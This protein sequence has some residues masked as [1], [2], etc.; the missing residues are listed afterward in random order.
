MTSYGTLQLLAA[1]AATNNTPQL[2][3]AASVNPTGI[4]NVRV[5]EDDEETMPWEK[6][7]WVPR[8]PN[9]QPK[10]ASVIREELQR[11]IDSSY[12]SQT[13]IINNEL[14]VNN[15]SF[16]KFMN[17]KSYKNQWSATQNGTYWAAA[18]LLERRAYEKKHAKKRQASV[19]KAAAAAPPT[20]KRKSTGRKSSDGA[21][22]KQRPVT[23]SK[24]ESY[25]SHVQLVTLPEDSKVFDSCQEVI[26]KIKEFL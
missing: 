8:M 6:E 17:P 25:M 5:D 21:P 12:K 11:Y 14:L 20:K 22:A 15:N 24:M 7:G 2:S 18:R 1:I 13:Y 19:A 10:S 26:A 16:R 3:L 4:V 9:G 23:S